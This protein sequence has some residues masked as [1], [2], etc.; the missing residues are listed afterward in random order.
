MAKAQTYL[1]RLKRLHLVEAVSREHCIADY[2]LIIMKVYLNTGSQLR[3][4]EQQHSDKSSPPLLH[5]SVQLHQYPPASPTS[6]W[7]VHHKAAPV[8]ATY[9]HLPCNR[10]TIF[11]I[12]SRISRLDGVSYLKDHGWHMDH[13]AVSARQCLKRILSTKPQ[14]SSS[15]LFL[16]RTLVCLVTRKPIGTVQAFQMRFYVNKRTSP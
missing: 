15:R 10:R 3:L 5:I 4:R 9:P 2:L 1:V 14:V 7:K 6:T 8:S 16:L 11:V 12:V 13:Q